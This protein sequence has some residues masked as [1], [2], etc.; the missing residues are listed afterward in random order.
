MTTKCKH[1]ESGCP[2]VSVCVVL[3]GKWAP[4]LRREGSVGSDFFTLADRVPGSPQSY[5]FSHSVSEARY[6]VTCI[7]GS[8]VF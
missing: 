2:K 5:R 1:P 4:R 6:D 3:G 7:H 8:H